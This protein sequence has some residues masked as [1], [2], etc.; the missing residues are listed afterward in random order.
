MDR[1]KQ[2]MA[3][4]IAE[5]V[6]KHPKS[7]NSF[8]KELGISPAA[9]SQ[10]VNE[11]LDSVSMDTLIEAR[12]KLAIPRVPIIPTY[13]HQT[14]S[15]ACRDASNRH[16][17][18]A[19]AQDT[20]YGKT[21]GLKAYMETN[22]MAT[23]VLCSPFHRPKTW[24]YEVQRSMGLVQSKSVDSAIREVSNI[25]KGIN[26]LLILDEVDKLPPKVIPMI[27]QLYDR[28][29]SQAG[30][31]LVG[32]MVLRKKLETGVARGWVGFAE[33]YD[34]IERWVPLQGPTAE[35]VRTLCVFAGITA[36]K[37]QQFMFK[38]CVNFRQLTN[39]LKTAV[40]AEAAGYDINDVTVIKR[41]PVG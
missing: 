12:K 28:L 21:S 17:M 18:L 29:E 5:L 27:Q 7:Q 13:N 4:S 11:K 23:Y 25:L 41:L 39:Y 10:I 6:E 40:D 35:E 16:R 14:I 8:A 36:P 38:A 2:L 15:N 19:I 34:R 22:Q 24:I 33:F 1:I 26:G 20:G 30:I 31:V 32:T 9:L 37:V 3:R